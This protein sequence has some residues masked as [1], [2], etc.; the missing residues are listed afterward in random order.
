MGLGCMWDPWLDGA[1]P[2]GSGDAL[3]WHCW[4]RD[5]DN[6]LRGAEMGSWAVG[7]VGGASGEAAQGE[8]CLLL[9]SG[10]QHLVLH[11][12]LQEN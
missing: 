12:E 9:P 3:L 8:Q 10:P 7:K 1:G 6:W 5:S 4:G 2:W 11:R